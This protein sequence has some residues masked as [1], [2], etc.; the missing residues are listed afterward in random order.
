MAVGAE[1]RRA[2]VGVV[3]MRLPRQAWRLLERTADDQVVG[4]DDDGH[5]AEDRLEDASVP[6]LGGLVLVARSGRAQQPTALEEDSL[7]VG[8]EQA[9]AKPVDALA[10]HV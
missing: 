2:Q 3:E 10:D 1:E 8:L 9:G 4:T 6:E 5:P 7:V